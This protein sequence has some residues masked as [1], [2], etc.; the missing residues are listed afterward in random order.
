ML[1]FP[2]DLLK[3]FPGQA[4]P[5]SVGALFF[6]FYI[7]SEKIRFDILCESQ[8]NNKKKIFKMLSAIILLSALRV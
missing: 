1:S 5:V 2:V 7:F 6:Y 8:K 4:Y 3:A